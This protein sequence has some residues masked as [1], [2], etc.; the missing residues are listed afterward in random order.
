LPVAV[1]SLT[2]PAPKYDIVADASG[3]EIRASSPKLPASKYNITMPTNRIRQYL[4]SDVPDFE[5]PPFSDRLRGIR[6]LCAVLIL[7]V[8]F[9]TTGVIATVEFALGGRP[10]GGN[11]GKVSGVPVVT[12]A[13]A[14]ASLTC[15]AVASMVVPLI[16][17]RGVARVLTSPADDP[18]DG[19]ERETEPDRL[20]RVYAAGKFTEFALAEGAAITTAILFHLTAD[21]LMLVFIAAMVLFMLVKFPTLGKAKA[22][23]A[24]IRSI[25][26]PEA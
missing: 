2:L 8:L 12:V 5:R 4:A 21:R 18:E 24:S 6:M 7:G 16:W 22:W 3:S 20:W 26:E 25:S 14:F 17:K 9:L 10:L 23:F 11:A 19:A 13:V 15:V 1:S